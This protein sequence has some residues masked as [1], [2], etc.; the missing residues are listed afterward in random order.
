MKNSLQMGELLE[1]SK[2]FAI[3]M[4]IST[5]QRRRYGGGGGGVTVSE[6]HVAT[7][8]WKKE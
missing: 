7:R 1:I 6:Q 8:Q 4:A 2:D 5:Q 3:D